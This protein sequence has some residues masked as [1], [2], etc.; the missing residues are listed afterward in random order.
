MII[1]LVINIYF[2]SILNVSYFEPY[3]KINLSFQTYLLSD[4]HGAHIGNVLEE[5]GIYNFSYFSDSYLDILRKL[6]Y[7]IKNSNIKRAII[8]ADDHLLSL[9]RDKNNNTDRSLVFESWKSSTNK[10]KISKNYFKRYVVLANPKSRDF[11]RTYFKS[12]VF[13]FFRKD[14]R[15]SK[16]WVEMSEGMRKGMSKERVAL[17]FKS[18]KKSI[19]SA[20][21][22]K[23]III[24]CKKHKI[25]LLA[26]KFPLSRNFLVELNSN[27]YGADEIFVSNQIR[28]LDY[29]NIFFDN[30]DYFTD[31]DHLN[32]R[33]AKVF[34]EIFLKDLMSL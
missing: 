28:I 30:D 4:S 26:I 25:K 33:G 5:G 16:K 32:K 15:E 19:M 13:N 7:L 1:I 34:S 20:E 31:Q 11:I 22:L 3:E 24:L 9:Y 14:D 10:Y 29:K 12:K 8:S 21:Y 2:Y 18:A 27:N 17:Q 6:K 23:E